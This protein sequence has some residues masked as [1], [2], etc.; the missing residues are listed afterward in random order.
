MGENYVLKSPKKD[1]QLVPDS[2]IDEFFESNADNL[3]DFEGVLD[4]KDRGNQGEGIMSSTY[5]ELRW[6][7]LIEWDELSINEVDQDR[8]VCDRDKSA[9]REGNMVNLIGNIKKEI[10]GYWEE[11]V[12]D[13][14]DQ[15]HN[16]KKKSLN[17]SL[18]YVM[19]AWSN[20]G[21]CWTDDFAQSTSDNGY[22]RFVKRES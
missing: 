14:E 4:I 12:D 6:D 9:H 21:P 13:D 20:R 10:W 15:E 1:E 19:D 8:G 17:L 18:N 22:G 16:E 2:I 7:H 11:E 5:D 3:S